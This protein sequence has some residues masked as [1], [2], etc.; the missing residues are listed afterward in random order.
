M[1]FLNFSGR[2]PALRALA[3]RKVRQILDSPGI[4]VVPLSHEA[5]IDAL[6]FYEAR[7]DK[8][9]SLTDCLSMQI[10]AGR[11]IQDVLTADRHFGQ[12]GFNVLL[13]TR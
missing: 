1:E 11:D 13:Q 4:E 6:A 10:M 9:Y 2:R 3:A 7:P 12:E 5:F 8:R